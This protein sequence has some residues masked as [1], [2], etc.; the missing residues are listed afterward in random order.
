LLIR[1]SRSRAW[2]RNRCVD[3]SLKPHLRELFVSRLS[4]STCCTASSKISYTSA[5][6]LHIHSSF[7]SLS[8]HIQSTSRQPQRPYQWRLYQQKKGHRLHP[9]LL[10]RPYQ[11]RLYQQKKGHRLLLSLLQRLHQWRRHQQK[12]GHRLHRSLP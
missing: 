3:V 5:S 11:W 9:S 6:R 12:K 8:G 7:H 1:L 2:S 10:Q 4:H